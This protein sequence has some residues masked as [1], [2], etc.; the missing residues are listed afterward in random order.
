[1]DS[2][3]AHALRSKVLRGDISAD[4]ASRALGIWARL[5]IDRFA[6]TGLLGR[7]WALRPNLTA[8]DASYV[9]LAEALGCSLVTADRRLSRADGPTCPITVV[10][11]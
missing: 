8:Y 10:V 4:D 1:M 2:E 9:A 3:V 6:V 5:G 11:S 7:V